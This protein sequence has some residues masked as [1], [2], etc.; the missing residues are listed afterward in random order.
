M[1]HIKKGLLETPFSSRPR[2]T[3]EFKSAYVLCHAHTHGNKY[4]RLLWDNIVVY[5]HTQVPQPLLAEKS[6]PVSVNTQHI[7]A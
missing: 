7:P 2:R 1:L 5:Q 3:S 4:L 6:D